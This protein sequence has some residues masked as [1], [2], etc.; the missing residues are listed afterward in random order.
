MPYD[1]RKQGDEWCVHKKTDPDGAIPEKGRCHSTKDAAEKQ[2]AAMMASEF[3]DKS[4]KSPDEEINVALPQFLMSGFKVV[5]NKWWGLWTNAF[6][7]RERET[8]STKA[9]EEYVEWW[10]KERP[11]TPLWFWHIPFDIGVT[12]WMGGEGR[13]AIAAGTLNEKG[14]KLTEYYEKHP[15]QKLGMSHMYLWSPTHKRNG[16]YEW[17]RTKELTVLPAPSAANEWTLFTEIRSSG[18]KLTDEK[19]AKL[20]EIFGEADARAII[21]TA[22]IATKELERM[23]VR[24]KEVKEDTLKKLQGLV[25]ALTDEDLK[26]QFQEVVDKVVEENAPVEEAPAE[27]AA[28]AEAAPAASVMAEDKADLPSALEPAVEAAPTGDVPVATPPAPMPANQV[29]TMDDELIA[30]LAAKIVELLGPPGGAGIEELQTSVASLKKELVSHREQIAALAKGDQE[31]V[32]E[33]VAKMPKAVVYRHSQA[34]A[35]GSA[36]RI[37]EKQAAVVADPLK[38]TMQESI[39]AITDTRA[40]ARGGGR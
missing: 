23:G 5:G 6:E 15:E 37:A 24:Y 1:I 17:F 38:M 39:K 7:D 16:V 14:M 30:M 36:T 9:I 18:V 21:A 3:G 13:I 35:A 34:A 11:P 40:K 2:I 33:L 25:D 26:T 31:K 20:K 29:L 8:F 12:T 28:P 10:W 19:V 4:M 27:E 32:K 22:T